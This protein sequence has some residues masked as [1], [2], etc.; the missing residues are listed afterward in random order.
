[1]SNNY[2]EKLEFDRVLEILSNICITDFGKRLAKDL[3]PKS[4]K[5]DVLISLKET[6]EATSLIIKNLAPEI[7]PIADITYISKIL[8]SNGALNMKALLEV[9]KILKLSSNLKKYYSIDNDA[10]ATMFPIL[11]NYFTSLYTNLDIEKSIE[12]SIIDENTIAD[13]A[14]YELANI[15][16][17]K[18]NLEETIKNKLNSFI[19]SATYSKYIQE[20]VITIRNDRYVIPVKE[21]YKSMIK[22][23]IHDV[24][25]SGATVFIEPMAIFELNNEISSLHANEN[26]EIDKILLHLSGLLYP[27]IDELKHTS[28][29][30]GLIDFIFA[31][32]KY[33][34]KLKCSEPKLNDNK[35]IDLINARH[36][37]IDEANVVPIDINL[38]KNFNTLVITGPNTGGKT[39]T[40]KTVGL[41]TVMA[42]SGL[43][44]PADENSSIFVFDEVFADIGDEQSIQESLSTFSSHISNIIDIL[45][46]STSNS[47]VLLDELGSGTDPI[48]GSSLAISILEAF[49]NKGILTISTTHYPEIKNY[50]LVTDGFENASSDF[51]LEHLKPTYKLLIGIPGKSNAFAISSKLGLDEDIIN[52]AY[53]FINSDD[54]SIEELLKN[55]YDDKIIIENEKEEIEKNLAQVELLR[56]S[57]E[58]KNSKLNEK[59]FSIIENAKIEARKILL[60]AKDEAS[61]TIQAINK[62]Y[63]NID[64]SSIKNLNNIRNK[65]NQSIKDISINNK[66]NLE[67]DITSLKKDEIFVGMN[68]YITSL[69]QYATVTSLPNKSND[70]QIQLGSV[71]MMVNI[72][73]VIKS[74]IDNTKKTYSSSSYKTNKTR[75]ATTEINVIGYNVDEAIFVID[76]YLDDCVLSK[77]NT[78]RIVH[79]KG[80]GAL[81]NGIHKYLKTS[82]YVKSFRLG[83]FGE[84]EMGVTIVEL[85]KE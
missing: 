71:K 3:R 56:K 82:K 21:E 27:I 73:N 45:K 61:N 74:D 75:Q 50:A 40:L 39:V 18:R 23:F 42:C 32:A 25:S 37:F 83:T 78:I 66:D 49:F 22:G 34:I 35:I 58:S 20:N 43:H 60:T 79:G 33:S 80:T 13:N 70:V 81:R 19:H 10:S 29:I 64:N 77:L 28:K 51:D 15:R 41:L 31:K 4:T 11:E 69:S 38:G 84:G 53:S 8:D 54:I 72:N 6:T 36:P 65:I 47:L 44:I 85:K 62:I 55:I 17:K 14:S 9:C 68:V 63:D 16:R 12:N 26:I 7:I 1:M 30:I 59:E 5:E 48:E 76:K 57:L 24:S 67:K 46:T 2:I 52:R